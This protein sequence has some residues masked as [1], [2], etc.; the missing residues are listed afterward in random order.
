MKGRDLG[1]VASDVQAR[2]DKL[3]FPLGYYAVLQG[4]YQELN[5]ARRRLEL[6]A[7]LA[8]AGDFRT[9]ATVL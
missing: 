7:V 6:F 8:L 9:S 4:E 3:A 2:L 1:A 5:A